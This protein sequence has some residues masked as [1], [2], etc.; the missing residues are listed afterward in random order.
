MFYFKDVFRDEKNLIYLFW[1]IMGL[2]NKIFKK[3]KSFSELHQCVMMECNVNFDCDYFF[4]INRDKKYLKG[5]EL[6]NDNLVIDGNGH[7]ID[8]AEACAPFIINAKN[9][10]LK[11]IIFKDCH[12]SNDA[13]VLIV[14]KNASLKIKNCEFR[15]NIGV[16][17]GVIDNYGELEIA[18]SRF[19]KNIG[20]MGGCIYND[21][22]LSV[23]NSSFESNKSNNAGAIQNNV[24]G[25]LNIENC[26]FNE[27]SAIPK[28]E[29]SN[30]PGV[31][32][33]GGIGNFGKLSVNKCKFNDNT[34]QGD[35]GA[36]ANQ[37]GT[38][39]ISDSEFNKNR[40]NSNG[41]AIVSLCEI[42]I[43]NSI[44]DRN[45]SSNNGGSC[46]YID[47]TKFKS[48]NCKFMNSINDAIINFGQMELK[49]PLFEGNNRYCIINYSSL[50]LHDSNFIN[51]A[52]GI[53]NQNKLEINSSYFKDNNS[54]TNFIYNSSLLKIN[55]GKVLQNNIDNN[56]IFNEGKLDIV[57]LKFKGNNSNTLIYNEKN[58]EM[59]VSYCEFES[60]NSILS[61]I[62]NDGKKASIIHPIFKDNSS[63]NEFSDNIVNVTDLTLIKPVIKGLKNPNVQNDGDLLI[64]QSDESVLKF[65]S[66]EGEVELIGSEERTDY[67]ESGFCDLR[68]I[69]NDSSDGAIVLES[70]FKLTNSEWDFYE[71]GIELIN[72]GLH[73]DGAGHV[74]DGN[75]KSRI[76]CIIGKNIVLKNIIFKNS[77]FNSEF[78]NH[79]NGG[80]AL[81]VLKDASVKLVNCKFINCYSDENGGVILNRGAMTLENN[82]F[83]NCN[84]ELFGGIIYNQ[85]DII[86]NN[87]SFKDVNSKIS[88]IYNDGFLTLNSM[89]FENCHSLYVPNEIFNINE[90]YSNENLEGFILNY[91]NVNMYKNEENI[92]FLEFSKLIELA[93]ERIILNQDIVYDYSTDKN[94]TGPILIEK[95][96]IIDGNN[97]IID[98]AGSSSFFEVSEGI[99]VEFKNLIFKNGSSKNDL[100]NIHSNVLFENCRFINNKP[101]Y[102]ANL[103]NFNEAIEIS[104]CAF[105]NNSSK[106]GSLIMN[107]KNGSIC[108]SSDFI[109]NYSLENSLITNLKKSSFKFEK[110]KF[111]NNY[112]NSF[113]HSILINEGI[114]GIMK[115]IFSFNKS[116]VPGGVITNHLSSLQDSKLIVDH[117]PKKN[118]IRSVFSSDKFNVYEESIND[119]SSSLPDSDMNVVLYISE[120]EFLHNVSVVFAG[121]LVN[122]SKT[123]SYIKKSKFIKNEIMTDDGASVIEN[124]PEGYLSV[125]ESKFIDNR[126]KLKHNV[127]EKNKSFNVGFEQGTI[128]SFKNECEIIDCEFINNE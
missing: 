59:S 95:N 37:K 21:N 12:G 94:F 33:G 19:V 32:C 103:M 102:N 63:E 47:N 46:L 74:I 64:K 11:N 26:R 84:C 24:N 7:E 40:C 39:F 35:G 116:K 117:V 42:E 8:G 99:R 70:D 110:T 65:I 66:G 93:N 62:Y 114:M 78:D 100:I 123:K 55:D 119:H 52:K 122:G 57:K 5:I 34:A 15:G 88:T 56:F 72:D 44:F 113:N 6:S 77:Y 16:S 71:G 109:S 80:G 101:R 118:V 82:L 79:C 90:I 112:S 89:N 76:F 75:K 61:L 67:S 105:V 27:N 104:N 111:I 87:D 85:G 45:D 125:E 13:G 43:E 3:K 36:I 51:N 81:R 107:Q 120:S 4:K 25:N 97:H 50:K 126:S 9:V 1:G 69:I 31:G 23:I 38:I 29:L 22:S 68:K 128:T 92:S 28:L 54:S 18:D 30:Q 83:E 49:N 86:S 53:L 48:N 106:S 17:A 2:L 115:S 41:G 127:L 58:A 98:G 124:Y 108:I 14:N 73:I 60:N 91:G 121:V 20:G 96:I 10:I